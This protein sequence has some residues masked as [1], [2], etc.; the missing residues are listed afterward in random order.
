ML[1]NVMSIV[2]DFILKP[3][4]A[5]SNSE[6]S[7]NVSENSNNISQLEMNANEE[8]QVVK[9]TTDY[10]LDNCS[11]NKTNEI[12]HEP[13]LEAKNVIDSVLSTTTSNIDCLKMLLDNTNL[14]KSK[15]N[16]EMSFEFENI[17]SNKTEESLEQTQNKVKN[18]AIDSEY[19]VKNK[20]NNTNNEEGTTLNEII[21]VHAE[22]VNAQPIEW[23]DGFDKILA[24]IHLDDSEAEN[25][26]HLLLGDNDDLLN[27]ELDT[28]STWNFQVIKP[29]STN[30]ETYQCYSDNIVIGDAAV[31]PSRSNDA[32][33]S[34]P[35]TFLNSNSANTT[36]DNTTHLETAQDDTTKICSNKSIIQI[37]TRDC[38]TEDAK[39]A[40]NNAGVISINT[41]IHSIQQI[42]TNSNTYL[43]AI[44]DDNTNNIAKVSNTLQNSVVEGEINDSNEETSD[45]R[46]KNSK[47]SVSVINSDRSKEINPI[48]LHDQYESDDC[49]YH[50][51]DF[52]IITEEEAK[53][54]GLILNYLQ[55]KTN[56]TN[57]KTNLKSL[58]YQGPSSFLQ[59]T[60]KN[61]RPYST[62]TK[63]SSRHPRLSSRELRSPGSSSENS[64]LYFRN[65]R[66]SLIST[67]VSAGLTGPI[68]SISGSSS[69]NPGPSSIKPGLSSVNP[70]PSSVNP[71]PSSSLASPEH[72]C[73]IPNGGA[74]VNPVSDFHHINSGIV[75]TDQHHLENYE[76]PD[77]NDIANM[78]DSKLITPLIFHV[79]TSM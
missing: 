38:D 9:T 8:K 12:F 41:E 79:K 59:S 43:E 3:I 63:L 17:M 18:D 42:N 25:N 68:S 27:K 55:C 5:T 76:V 20:A 58:G 13:T 35:D 72:L 60:S 70:G 44:Q 14:A 1:R 74:L 67:G 34:K 78:F 53:M 62:S 31:Y 11:I 22:T 49:G 26:I 37:A 4:K 24:K 46:F 6:E 66:S 30:D 64:G 45:K 54:D 28:E 57:S 48:K 36:E 52:E 23:L 75:E 71:G 65:L 50:S 21:N 10:I 33:Y 16:S 51:S 47:E 56:H 32:M 40:D 61:R 19:S 77:F 73:H 29:I 39:A 15:V 7:Q 69:I 2:Q